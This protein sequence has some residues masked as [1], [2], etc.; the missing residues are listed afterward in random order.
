MF[1][2][3]LLSDV[4]FHLV[5]SKYVKYW[6]AQLIHPTTICGLWRRDDDTS[7]PCPVHLQDRFT[8]NGSFD[9]YGLASKVNICPAKAQEFAKPHTRG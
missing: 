2:G 6:F 8:V 5:P 3:H 9:G 7:P 4:L 1:T